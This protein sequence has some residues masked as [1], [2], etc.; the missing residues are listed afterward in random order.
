MELAPAEEDVLRR[1]TRAVYHLR[2]QLSRKKLMPVFGAGASQSIG[3]PNWTDL[4]AKIADHPE[5]CA[6]A[7]LERATSQAS[8]V[9]L[10]F[11]HFRRSKLRAEVKA[12]GIEDEDSNSISFERKVAFQW[13]EIIHSCLYAS[14][15]DVDTHPY[16]EA[17]VPVIKQAPLTVN[18]NFDDT[19]QIL[20]SRAPRTETEGQGFETVWEPSVQYRHTSPVIYHPNGFLPRKLEHNPSPSVIFLEDSFADQLIDAQRGHY[21]TLLSHLFRFTSILIGLSL[22]DATLKH[23]LRQSATANPGHVHY[24]VAYRD[25]AS[26]E[27][28][29]REA[30]TRDSNFDT[31]NLVTL[32]LT[33]AQIAALANLVSMPEREFVLAVHELKLPKSY[34]FYFSGAVGVGKTT[35][36]SRFKSIASFDEWLEPKDP[37]LHKAADKLG[38]EDEKKVDT[39][40]DRQ[41]RQ[42]NFLVARA[43]TELVVVDRSPIDPVAFVA[44]KAPENANARAKELLQLYDSTPGGPC[45]GKVIFMRGNPAVMHVRAFDRHKDGSPEYLEKL[46]E[47]FA[48]L[49]KIPGCGVR[50]LETVDMSLSEVVRAIS[51][52]V[53]LEH[54]STVDLTETLRSVGIGGLSLA[55]SAP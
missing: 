48:A 6:R 52:I 55:Q 8:R 19:L 50:A 28:P 24:Y 21:S 12:G 39:W 32:F 23:L 9:Q 16:L 22:A 15:R 41:F 5:V 13:R 47:Y 20:L 26:R 40:I 33:T 43:E 18:Y 51:R 7:V 25:D 10:V 35:A 11:H 34:V 42:K 45:S 27:A 31:Y 29:I 17:F 37:L 14:A 53:H 46:Q 1:Y 44:T 49:W 36:L 4:V 30:A 38:A 54:Y 2:G 3:L